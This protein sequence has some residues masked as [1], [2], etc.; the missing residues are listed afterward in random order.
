MISSV[1]VQS[2]KSVSVPASM[3]S[4]RP[5]C[6]PLLCLMYT[7]EGWTCQLQLAM[8]AML[9]NIT[10][11]CLYLLVRKNYYSFR[12]FW[13]LS[14]LK[15]LVITTS[16]QIMGLNGNLWK[17][18]FW[19]THT[20]TVMCSEHHSVSI[21]IIN[22]SLD[23]TYIQCYIVLQVQNNTWKTDKQFSLV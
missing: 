14:I 8:Q 21:F 6:L 4:P 17:W 2:L 10:P 11:Y 5:S 22:L 1:F 18:M 16:H 23:L 20:R 15:D 9:L 19:E 3:C 13:R 7:N 12:I